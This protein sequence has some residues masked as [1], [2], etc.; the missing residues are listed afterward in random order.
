MPDLKMLTLDKTTGRLRLGM[1]RPPEII[2]GIDLLVQSVVLLYLN[3]GGRSI[4]LPGRAGGLRSYVGV[5]YDHED[6]AEILADMRLMTSRVEQI[7][8]EEQ[9]LTNRP[10]SERLLALHVI[11]IIPDEEQ[12]EIDLQVQVVNEEQ[13]TSQAVVTL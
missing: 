3:K 11:D 5:N 2:K 10:P 13:Q 8:I 7:I 6:P 1:P 12:L 9:V 4:F